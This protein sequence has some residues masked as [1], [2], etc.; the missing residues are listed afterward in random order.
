MQDMIVYVVYS[1]IYPYLP[2]GVF[3][4][5][6]ECA[7]FMQVDTIDDGVTISSSVWPFSF[8]H[9]IRLAISVLLIYSP[10]FGEII[11]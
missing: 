5:Q 4:T 2:V 9:S 1:V 10:P 6:K 8:S 3:D 7:E 11:A